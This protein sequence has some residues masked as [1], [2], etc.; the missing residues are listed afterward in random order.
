MAHP[1]DEVVP[2]DAPLDQGDLVPGCP[3]L[4]WKEGPPHLYSSTRTREGLRDLQKAI[5]GLLHP[6]AVP[7]SGDGE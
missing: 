4:A 7:V 5:L 3:L 6:A 2:A 1:W